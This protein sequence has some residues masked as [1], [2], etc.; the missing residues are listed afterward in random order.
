VI[1]TQTVFFGQVAQV[2]SS[3]PLPDSTP[4]EVMVSALCIMGV[5]QPVNESRMVRRKTR[6][7]MKFSF[8]DVKRHHTKSRKGCTIFSPRDVG[9]GIDNEMIWNQISVGMANEASTMYCQ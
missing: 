9:R 5:T 6:R 8:S 2:A 1:T 7:D 3:M 4:L